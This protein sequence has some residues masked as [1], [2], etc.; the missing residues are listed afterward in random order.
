ML[1]DKGGG[2]FVTDAEAAEIL[3]GQS[4]PI[5]PTTT[6]GLNAIA[7]RVS[8]IVEKVDR[9][10]IESIGREVEAVL[11]TLSSTLHE[12]EALAG[13]ANEDLIPGLSDSLAKLEGALGSADAMISPDSA[14]AQDLER[15]VADLSRAARSI[16]G[17]AE[18]LEE[19][20]E[21]LL[22]GKGE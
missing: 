1:G 11:A 4:Y 16:R 5:L 12:F 7:N 21:E 13:S 9:L 22:R 15:L 19:H 14:M 20:P 6:S 10:P 3:L 18:R 17:L 2:D 8:R